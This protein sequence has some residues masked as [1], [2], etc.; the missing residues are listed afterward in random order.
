MEV[1]GGID[2]EVA[3]LSSHDAARSVGKQIAN[4]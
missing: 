4:Y 3:V 2:L 1:H